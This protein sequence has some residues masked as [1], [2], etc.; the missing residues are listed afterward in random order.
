MAGGIALL[1]SLCCTIATAVGAQ[2]VM[3]GDISGKQIARAL[4]KIPL[5]PTVAGDKAEGDLRGI[6][7]KSCREVKGAVG[8]YLSAFA[9]FG[10][11]NVGLLVVQL[12]L[13]AAAMT[14]TCSKIICAVFRHSH[15]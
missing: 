8:N 3:G 6:C 4:E 10:H 15:A 13:N 11:V 5:D 7:P 14:C 2:N 9:G 12:L 1:V